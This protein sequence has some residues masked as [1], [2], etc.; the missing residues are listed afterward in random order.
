M[1]FDLHFYSIYDNTDDMT[2]V[3]CC[4]KIYLVFLNIQK[5]AAI[6]NFFQKCVIGTLKNKN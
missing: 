4:Y 5:K 3:I 1:E 6:N 2:C